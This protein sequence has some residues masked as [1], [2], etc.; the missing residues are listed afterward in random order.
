MAAFIRFGS[1][2]F[3][4]HLKVAFFIKQPCYFFSWNFFY[5]KNHPKK[6]VP[7]SS[8]PWWKKIASLLFIMFSWLL[9]MPTLKNFSLPTKLKDLDFF[10]TILWGGVI[11]TSPMYLGKYWTN[12]AQN[13]PD[14]KSWLRNQFS[15]LKNLK[16]VWRH[17]LF[18]Y[19][20]QK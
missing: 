6:L 17:G 5:L 20:S 12:S 18:C 19:H 4:E 9:F 14:G 16:N 3:L 7:S 11:F 15:T 13:W 8:L 2:C 10:N 1:T